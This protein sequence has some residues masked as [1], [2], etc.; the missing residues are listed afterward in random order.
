MARNRWLNA[1]PTTLEEVARIG[2]TRLLRT[3]AS[4]R[5]TSTYPVPIINGCGD[6]VY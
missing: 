1:F 2:V 3:R 5:E 4:V 6:S